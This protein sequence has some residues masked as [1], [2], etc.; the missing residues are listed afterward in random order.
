MTFKDSISIFA[1]RTRVTLL[2]LLLWSSAD[3]EN[4][5]SASLETSYAD[6]HSDL[7]LALANN[8]Q[9]EAFEQRYEAALQRI[10]QASAL[11]DPMFQVTSFVES[12][13]TRTGPQSITSK[14]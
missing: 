8:P 13:Q 1:R 11:P 3:A 10:P 6:L 12:I 4:S 9:L 5:T 7:S 14:P 2:C